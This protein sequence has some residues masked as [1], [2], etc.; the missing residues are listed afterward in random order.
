MFIGLPRNASRSRRLPPGR[1][2]S[3][4]GC[5]YYCSLLVLVSGEAA[6][7]LAMLRVVELQTCVCA[8]GSSSVR[9]SF[10]HIIMTSHQ[11]EIQYFHVVTP[12]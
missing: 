5:Y 4:S 7:V 10:R 1:Y 9:L 6:S 8:Q 2:R 3:A 11:N 12:E